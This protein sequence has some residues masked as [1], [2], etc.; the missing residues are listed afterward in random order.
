VD[1]GLAENADKLLATV[2]QLQNQL[3]TSGVAPIGFGAESISSLERLRTTPAPP[4]PI[5]FI[6]NTSIDRDHTGGNVK[7]GAAGRKTTGGN[8]AQAVANSGEGAEIF[9]H[10]NVARRMNSPEKGAEEFPI[11]A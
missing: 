2:R 5:R 8:V 9:A 6:L 3:A 10:E 1:T 11:D 7:I 4:E